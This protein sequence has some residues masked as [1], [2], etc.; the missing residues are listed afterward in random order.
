MTVSTRTF[1]EEAAEVWGAFGAHDEVGKLRRVLVRAPGR[2]LLDIDANAWDTDAQALVDPCGKWYWTA[3][4]AP[5]LSGA[6]AQHLE[7]VRKLEAAGVEVT[8]ADPANAGFSKAVYVRDPVLMVPHGAVIC[9]PAVQMR[10]GEEVDLAAQ[11]AGLGVPLL[12]TIV[13]DATL[14]GGSFLKLRPGRAAIG[15]SIRCNQ[16]GAIQLEELL[17]R[18]GWQLTIVSLPGWTIHLDLHLAMLDTDLALVD[19][20]HLPFGFLQDLARMGFELLEAAPEEHWGLNLLCVGPRKVIMADGNPRTAERLQ[21]A[22]VEVIT[23]PYDAIQ[24]NGGGI[25]C[26]TQELLRDPADWR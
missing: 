12:Q 20:E 14:E 18:F 22:G 11:L 15:L 24:P 3:P 13:G 19:T 6:Q 16:A 8:Y 26:S 5:D 25:H 1:E 9:R 23:T 17:K 10:R 2:E 7:L 4:D 21:Q